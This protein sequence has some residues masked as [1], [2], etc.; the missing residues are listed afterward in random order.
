MTDECLYGECTIC[1]FQYYDE[2]KKVTEC[3]HTFHRE[4]LDTWLQTNNTC[5]LCRHV[6]QH[7]RSTINEVIP[8]T[9]YDY[10][11]GFGRGGGIMRLVAY[12]AADIMLTSMYEMDSSIEQI[13]GD[14]DITLPSEAIPEQ[15]HSRIDTL[16]LQ[17]SGSIGITRVGSPFGLNVTYADDLIISELEGEWTTDSLFSGGSA[18]HSS[19]MQNM[20]ELFDFNALYSNSMT[21][22]ELAGEEIISDR[23]RFPSNEYFNNTIEEVD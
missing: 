3:N 1:L 22:A 20:G 17:P 14:I 18:I 9:N 8:Y 23:Y 15:H 10:G 13:I 11:G 2:V 4:C 19:M 6:L 7:T 21:R 16:S 5:P 12:G